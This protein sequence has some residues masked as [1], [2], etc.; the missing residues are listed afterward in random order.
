MIKPGPNRKPLSWFLDWLPLSWDYHA[1]KGFCFAKD[2]EIWWFIQR[3]DYI[4]VLACAQYAYWEA[5]SQR[6]R[7]LVQEV[8]VGN[9]TALQPGISEIRSDN[10]D[11][12]GDTRKDE[13]GEEDIVDA[14]DDDGGDEDDECNEDDE[15]SF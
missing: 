15:D 7:L 12:S 14:V 3:G 9:G 8:F 6:A 13:F 1:Q 11:I 5:K 4:G 2:H 10:K